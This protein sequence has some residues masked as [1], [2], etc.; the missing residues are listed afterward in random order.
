MTVL[1]E[2]S[3]AD[4]THTPPDRHPPTEGQ[5]TPASDP[6]PR[7]SGVT[8]YNDCSP[9]SVCGP[10][11]PDRCP[12]TE[13]CS[14]NGYPYSP[15]G[16]PGVA[17]ARFL[18]LDLTRDCSLKCGH[19]YNASGPSGDKK[20]LKVLTESSPSVALMQPE[21]WFR[22]LHQAVQAGVTMIQLIGGEPTM[23]HGFTEV[24]TYAL[25]LGLKVEIY[26]NLVHVRDNWWPLFQI[27]A[28]SLATSYY[29]DDPAEHDEITGRDSHRKTRTNIARA[30]GLGI[31]IRVG[32]VRVNPTQ[33]VR[34]ARRDLEALGVQP[35][36]I[37]YDRVRAFGR[38]Q[39]QHAACDVNELCGRCGDGRAA[40]GPD[41]TV[42]P[43][44]MS[45]WLKAGNVKTAPIAG[46]LAGEEMA[47]AMALPLPAA[48]WRIGPPDAR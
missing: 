35:N 18:W 33:R 40:I 46:I 24:L 11:N 12:P 41:G 14:P 26:S 31:R 47:A 32:I 42:T 36:L 19:C 23:Y 20:L 9:D 22:V 13:V 30:I 43:C 8:I 48:K 4:V 15:G 3:L 16:G 27:P 38:G 34:E 21:D 1:E 37:G 44:I 39:G 45:S 17:A 25:N 29:S 5:Y 28:V 6:D 7:Q 10:D 2:Q